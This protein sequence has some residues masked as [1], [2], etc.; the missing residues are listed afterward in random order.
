MIETTTTVRLILASGRV[1]LLA[2]DKAKH[3]YNTEESNQLRQDLRQIS[4]VSD[5]FLDGLYSSAGSGILQQWSAEGHPQKCLD[6]LAEMEVL[7]STGGIHHT[8]EYFA[9]NRAP[10]EG[11]LQD[12]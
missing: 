4:Y 5:M 1:L 7:I 3:E 8:I 6:V 12:E 10:F 11:L 9:K 2:T